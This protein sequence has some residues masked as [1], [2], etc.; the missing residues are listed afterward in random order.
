[1]EDP[2]L[3]IIVPLF[4]EEAVIPQFYE[5]LKK[6]MDSQDGD[7]EII[8][9]NDGSTDRSMEALL[10]LR[11][12]DPRI[13]IIEF[14]RNFGHQIAIT[15]GLDHA[16]GKAVIVMDGDLQHPPEVIPKLIQKW[17]EGFELVYTVRKET[18]D[19]GYFKNL[20]AS[21]FYSLINKIGDIQIPKHGADFRLVDRRVLE[22]LKLMRE[23]SR[24]MRGLFNWVGYSQTSVEFEADVRYAGVT[25]YSFKKMIQFALDGITSFSS[26]PLRISTYFGF[27]VSVI[28]F[29]YAAFAIYARLFT[30]I[31]LPGWTSILVAV[32]FLGG[33]QLITIGL[34]GEY[35]G[36]IYNEVKQRPLYI[37][38]N[39]FGLE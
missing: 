26:F 29:L 20:S 18:K 17:K 38:R 11:Q 12:S 8:F 19:A 25:K 1:M 28:S 23:R 30:D 32:L 10:K 24:F 13:K 39:K 22:S 14:S 3:S 15:A 4:N 21:L 27:M 9:I 5:R 7:Y 35:I 31:A 37:I 2:L 16:Q 33:V 34:L 6:V 36:R